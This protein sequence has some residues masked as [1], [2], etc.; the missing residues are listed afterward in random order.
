LGEYGKGQGAVS[1]VGLGAAY[2]MESG[3]LDAEDFVVD[4]DCGAVEV[5]RGGNPLKP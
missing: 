5:D 2:P 4:L 1:G 3:A